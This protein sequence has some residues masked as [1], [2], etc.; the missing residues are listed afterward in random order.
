MEISDSDSSVTEE[1]PR[2]S[3]VEQSAGGSAEPPVYMLNAT[4]AFRLYCAVT[5]QRGIALTNK[6]V[7]LELC[8]HLYEAVSEVI[9]QTLTDEGQERA[10]LTPI[11]V[12]AHTRTVSRLYTCGGR[13]PY[14][15]RIASSNAE[16]TES[17]KLFLPTSRVLQLYDQERKDNPSTVCVGGA[18]HT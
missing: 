15:P 9:T 17:H 14:Q 7:Q 3:L 4:A 2:D 10:A 5:K 6:E 16:R 13:H 11:Q 8:A 12:S 1:E 18:T